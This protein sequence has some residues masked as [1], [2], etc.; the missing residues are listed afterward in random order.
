MG[1]KTCLEKQNLQQWMK[2]KITLKD[3]V[4]HSRFMQHRIRDFILLLSKMN[5]MY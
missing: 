5:N 1:R 4:P 3:M 2:G